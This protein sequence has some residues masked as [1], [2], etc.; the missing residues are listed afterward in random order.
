L[1]N[2]VKI[3]QSIFLINNNDATKSDLFIL[4]FLNEIWP[5]DLK[6]NNCD[7]NFFVFMVLIFDFQVFYK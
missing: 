7:L 3:V 1:K 6:Y 2:Y 5:K 4:L